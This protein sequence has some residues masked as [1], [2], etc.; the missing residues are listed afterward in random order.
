M[1]R[2]RPRR[3][4]TELG[5]TSS[6]DLLTTTNLFPGSYDVKVCALINFDIEGID[7]EIA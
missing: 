5:I 1:S 4:A 7:A 6:R 2:Q 3:T